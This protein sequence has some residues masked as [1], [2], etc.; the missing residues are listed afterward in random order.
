MIQRSIKTL[1]VLLIF[2][3][4]ASARSD[5]NSLLLGTIQFPRDLKQAIEDVPVIY[6]GDPA[7][8]QL[9]QT[10][11][12]ITFC[13]PR[14]SSQ[15]TFKLLIVEPQHIEPVSLT[16]KYQT[17]PTNLVAYH[18]I[19]AGSSYRYFNLMLLP[20]I[21]KNK[22]GI[23]AISYSWRVRE[24]RIPHEGRIPDDAVIMHAVP[25]WVGTVIAGSGFNFPT[26][27]MRSDLERYAGSSEEFKKKLGE[28]AL[29]RLD[30][31]QFEGTKQ[32]VAMKKV[33]NAIII[34]PPLRAAG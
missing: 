6:H 2:S 17:E 9:D 25:D 3:Q 14:E 11:K 29:A 23:N 27:Q 10:N 13:V 33:G 28:I 30:L 7:T 32:H 24:E 8:T 31:K 12:A 16:S 20:E 5:G 18:K 26:V 22:D 15:F 19:K 21:S 34:A 4:V 1:L